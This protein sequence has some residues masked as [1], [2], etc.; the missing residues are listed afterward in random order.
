MSVEKV[1]QKTPN[2]SLTKLW[3]T[4]KPGNQQVVNTAIS[5]PT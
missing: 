1:V 2:K 3:K 5:N 4:R